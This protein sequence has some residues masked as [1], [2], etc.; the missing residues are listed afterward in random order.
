[1]TLTAG[2]SGDTCI[3]GGE[4]GGAAIGKAFAAD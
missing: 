3:P 4:G 2:S 1:M